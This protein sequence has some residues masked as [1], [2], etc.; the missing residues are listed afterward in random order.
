MYIQLLLESCNPRVVLAHHFRTRT[1][2]LLKKKIHALPTISFNRA[3][4][5]F[6]QVEDFSQNMWD[7][8]CWTAVHVWFFPASSG[9]SW[10]GEYFCLAW[11]TSASREVWFCF[12][13]NKKTCLKINDRFAS[14]LKATNSPIL[15]ETRWNG[16]RSR[17]N[18]DSWPTWRSKES[19]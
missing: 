19:K 16:F 12:S 3:W 15:N 11:E 13:T 4:I 10:R 5:N 2:S 7:V 1:H 9:L 18:F 17:Q 8:K 6:N 14:K